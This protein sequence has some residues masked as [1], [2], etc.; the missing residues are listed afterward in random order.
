MLLKK[1]FHMRGAREEDA[2]F[3]PAVHL[4]NPRAR[5]RTLIVCEH[6]SNRVPEALDGLGLDPS[7]LDSH[8]AWDPGALGLA[9]ALA[10]RLDAPLVHG[11]LS[12]LVYDCNRPPDAPDAIPAVSEVHDIPGNIDLAQGA[13]ARR[14]AHVYR[15]FENRLAYAIKACA[16]LCLLV[17]VHSFTPVFRGERRSVEIGL[18]HGDD[19]RFAQAMLAGAPASNRFVTRI[20]EPYGPEDG[21]AHTLNAHGVANGL[22]N[23]MLEIRNDLIAT[24]DAQE[25]MA[26]LLAPWLAETL[27]GF[28][29]S[30]AAT[31]GAA[32]TA[33]AVS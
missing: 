28:G 14:V 3:G 8:I 16:G 21:V 24:S 22:L 10:G 5:S 25:A 1:I 12:R 4:H 30:A 29:P 23:V 19:P 6:A 15:P 17:T 11:G 20:N 27:E 7:L 2:G 13:R 31:A 32:P 26:G 9:K 18:L 33:R